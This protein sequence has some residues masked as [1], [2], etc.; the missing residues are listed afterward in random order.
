M[1]VIRGLFAQ[2]L[3]AFILSF[4]GALHPVGDSFAVFRP[5]IC[6]ILIPLALLLPI[7]WRWRMALAT[8]GL[9]GLA[10]IGW[11]MLPPSVSPSPDRVVIYQKNMFHQN[12]DL[13]GLAED[14]VASN[15]DFVTLQE[16]SQDNGPLLLNL[17]E[18]YPYQL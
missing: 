7:G 18:T 16:L 8:V 9:A 6:L 10:T 15:A 13:E 4:L 2:A 1:F 5:L 3:A 11:H 12:S 14:I 17:K